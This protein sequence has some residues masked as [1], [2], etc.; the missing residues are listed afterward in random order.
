MGGGFLCNR[1]FSNENESSMGLKSGEYAG[2]NSSF[3]PL[4]SKSV[5][6][7]HKA[8]NNK[9]PALDKVADLRCFVDFAIIHDNDGVVGGKRLHFF[10]KI[11]DKLRE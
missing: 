2:R 9:V 4:K 5:S 11:L 6:G 10:E 3:I 1:D 8:N 7:E